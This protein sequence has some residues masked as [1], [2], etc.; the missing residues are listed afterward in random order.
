MLIRLGMVDIKRT[1]GIVRIPVILLTALVC[2]GILINF[3]DVFIV[4]AWWAFV[5]VACAIATLWDGYRTVKEFGLPLSEA[6]ISGVATWIVPGATGLAIGGITAFISALLW[7]N[8]EGYEAI[9]FIVG[10][11][12]I[13]ILAVVGAGIAYVI[14]WV[15]GWLARR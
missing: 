4:M 11:V 1:F 13:V 2:V 8:L 15:G 12:V 10:A 9:A 7:G 14:G 6:G 3:L 5:L